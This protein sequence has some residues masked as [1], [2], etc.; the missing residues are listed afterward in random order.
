MKFNLIPTDGAIISYSN[1]YFVIFYVP[2]DHLIV[3][4]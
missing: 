1:I 4:F 3:T 2:T